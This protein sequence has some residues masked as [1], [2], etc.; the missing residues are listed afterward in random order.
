M[1]DSCMVDAMLFKWLFQG[2]GLFLL[3]GLDTTEDL[4]YLQSFQGLAVQ[5]YLH[6]VKSFNNQGCHYSLSNSNF[7]LMLGVFKTGTLSL[8]Q[9]NLTCGLF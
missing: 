2:Y 6:I 1:I 7:L 8:D 5:L 9:L 4:K 3:V